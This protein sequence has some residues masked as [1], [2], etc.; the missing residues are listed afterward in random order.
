MD[1]MD[2]TQFDLHRAYCRMLGH[3]VPFSYCRKVRDGLPCFRVLDC[4]FQKFPVQEFISNNYS[5]KEQAIIF[6]QPQNKVTT[7]I[8]LIERAKSNMAKQR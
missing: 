2:K 7:L 8:D 1:K 3:D 5:V 4:W 6:E